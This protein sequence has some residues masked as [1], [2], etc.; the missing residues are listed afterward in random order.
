MASVI[1]SRLHHENRRGFVSETALTAFLCTL[2]LV[3]LCLCCIA[4]LR[5]MLDFDSRVQDEISALQLRRIFLLS[6]DIQL[7]GDCLTFAYQERE[8]TLYRT[9]R[10]VIMTP[11]TQIFFPDVDTCGFVNENGIAWIVYEREGEQYRKAL[12]KMP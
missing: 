8:M 7:Y 10:N 9:G 2:M 12:A 3:P 6:D 4:P 5:G 11:G 1:L